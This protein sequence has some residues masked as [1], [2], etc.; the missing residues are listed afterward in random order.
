MEKMHKTSVFLSLIF[1]LAPRGRGFS[2]STRHQCA[3][4]HDKMAQIT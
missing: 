3:V 2:E 1:F 4:I